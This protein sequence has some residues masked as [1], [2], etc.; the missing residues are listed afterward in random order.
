MPKDDE[1]AGLLIFSQAGDADDRFAAVEV[2]SPTGDLRD[3]ARC[4]FAA[5]R[6]LD[7]LGL[8]KIYVEPCKEEGLGVAIMDRL[9]RCAAP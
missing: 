7:S 8:D 3:A 6:K 5:L 9:R 2:L 1:R 4:L